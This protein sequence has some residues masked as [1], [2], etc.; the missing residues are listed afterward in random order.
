MS[1]RGLLLACLAL[2]GTAAVSGQITESPYTVKPGSFLVEMDALSVSWDRDQ[3]GG[4]RTTVVAVAS[5]ILTVG[6]HDRLDVQV[7][8][9]L[10]LSQKVD[11]GGLSER[12]SGIGD[13]YLRAKLTVWGDEA[14]GSAVA[15]LPYV[16]FPTNRGGVGN[17]AVEGGL[18]VPWVRH[19]AGGGHLHAMGQ[20]DLAR[21]AADD[22]YDVFTFFSASLDRP[23]T[24][25]VG[26]Y[27]EVTAAK[28]T[29]GDPWASTVGAGAT[30]ALSEHAWW[31]FAVYRG[32]S[33]GAA[34]WNPVVRFNWG[35]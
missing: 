14:S 17:D 7:G 21:N 33:R 2:A 20:V 18:I 4:E 1:T 34:D 27:G 22:G 19:L 15:V 16:K 11:Q 25:R 6:L 24:R 8:A 28:G 30:L 12:N 35:F 13:V 29:G 23:L 32:L 5:T 10:F 9:D 26:I 3:P 31:D